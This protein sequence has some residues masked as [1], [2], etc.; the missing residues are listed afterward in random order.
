MVVVTA[1][2]VV[3]DVLVVVTIEVVVVTSAVVVVVVSNKWKQPYISTSIL[4]LQYM[5]TSCVLLF[6][7]N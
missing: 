2:V 5:I 3:P 1:M 4:Y 7:A 6:L